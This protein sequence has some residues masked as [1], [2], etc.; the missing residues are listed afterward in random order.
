[1]MLYPSRIGLNGAALIL[2]MLAAGCDQSARDGEAVRPQPHALGADGPGAG[3]HNPQCPEPVFC[4]DVGPGGD[5]ETNG[6]NITHI[7]VDVAAPC[8]SSASFYVYVDGEL[9]TNLHDQGGPCQGIA[10]DVWFPLTGNQS[11]ATVC[12]ELD[13]YT[14]KSVT[15]GA[16]AQGDCVS[17]TQH[18]SCAS[19]ESP[20]PSGSSSSSSSSSSGGGY[21]GS[22]SSSSGGGSC[23]CGTSSSSGG[24]YSSSSSSSSGGGSCT[25]GMSGSSGG[26]TCDKCH[27]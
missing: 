15:V 16:K 17:A 21:S 13:G 10:R 20:Y 9:V 1:M 8:V 11:T 23:T 19:C 26:C 4:F 22:S 12:V 14:P 3:G 25:C 24:G 5:V 18:A 27:H 7:F 6:K 2:A